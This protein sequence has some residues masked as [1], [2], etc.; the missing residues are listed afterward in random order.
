MRTLIPI[1][2][3]LLLSAYCQAQLYV[4]S[5]TILHIAEGANL[6]VGPNL[7]NE[8]IIQNNGTLTLYKDWTINNNYNGLEGSLRLLGNSNQRVAPPSL[9]LRELVIDNANGN[10]DFPGT[11]YIVLERLDLKSGN[12]KISD[13]TRFV[14]ESN[15]RVVGG[16]KFS[17]F[18]GTLI[19]MGSGEKLFPLGDEGVYHPIYLLDVRGADSEISGSFTREHPTDPA[20]GDSLI[21]VSHRG[22][23]NIKVLNG[24]PDR[25]HVRI[26]FDEHDLSELRIINNIRHR[27]NSPALAYSNDPAEEFRSLGVDR[28]L[29]SDS[30][31]FG[32]IFSEMRF[33]PDPALDHYFAVGLAPTVP[34]EGIYYIPEAFS[35]NASDPNNQTFKVFGEQISES[36]FN[37]QVYNR[38]GVVV[39]ST[40]SFLEANTIGWDGENQSTGAEEPAGLYY[41]TIRFQ[42][43]TGLPIQTK[44]AFYLVK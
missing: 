4:P 18:E 23:W 8:G 12:I 2:L 3:I 35:P 30:L 38:Y 44:G 14:L 42:F 1:S 36:G 10:V 11:E 33:D 34:N 25:T 26:D 24:N 29:N 37:L 39:Y 40:D 7:E 28:L 9:T 31:T 20:P 13:N 21:G 22:L 27:V 41:Y 17:H 16:S 32:Q 5:N 6:E 19:H 43:E 15:A